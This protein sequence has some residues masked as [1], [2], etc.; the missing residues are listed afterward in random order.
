LLVND[1]VVEPTFQNSPVDLANDKALQVHTW[2]NVALSPGD[3]IEIQSNPHTNG[4]IPE[5]ESTAFAR[6]RW[7]SVGFMPSQGLK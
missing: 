7:R 2:P 4:L 5:G 1:V 3:I 6:G